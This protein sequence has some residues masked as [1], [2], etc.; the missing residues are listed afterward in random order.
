LTNIVLNSYLDCNLL[1]PSAFAVIKD[2]DA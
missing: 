2:I 1:Q